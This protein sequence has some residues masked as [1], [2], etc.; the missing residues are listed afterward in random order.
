[1]GDDEESPV[2]E[3][4]LDRMVVHWYGSV[5][6]IGRHLAAHQRVVFVTDTAVYV[7]LPTGGVTR[8]M[9]VSRLHLANRAPGAVCQLFEAGRPCLVTRHES[10]SDRDDFI[11]HVRLARQSE[12][13]DVAEFSVH[14]VPALVF[15]GDGSLEAGKSTTTQQ[16]ETL[17]P[18]GLP[19]GY[20]RVDASPRA[21][22]ADISE[23]S[24]SQPDNGEHAR[25]TPPNSRT[26][27][28][29]FEAQRL[30]LEELR[31]SRTTTP[32]QPT[33][34]VRELRSSGPMA[35]ATDG[36]TSP[37][38][39]SPVTAVG[40]RPSRA[41]QA[42]EGIPQS[43]A[44]KN[45]TV[46]DA[47]TSSEHNRKAQLSDLKHAL[48]TGVDIADSP[49]LHALRNQ[50]NRQQQVID[51]LRQAA[52][53]TRVAELKRELDHAHSLISD[54]QT[55][56]RSQETTFAEMLRAQEAARASKAIQS[57]LE[58]QVSALSAERDELRAEANRARADADKLRAE[59][60]AQS[61]QHERELG[62]VREAFVQYDANVAEY[63][64]E[65]RLEHA[66]Q[67]DR[68]RR[69]E[70]EKSSHSARAKSTSRTHESHA[71]PAD[72]T[73]APDALR[74]ALMRHLNSYAN[75]KLNLPVGNPLP[76]L[77]ATPPPAH[78]IPRTHATR[79]RSLL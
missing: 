60:E 45:D 10:D 34:V 57:S 25:S 1:M 18:P 56:L 70:R 47:A 8:T 16:P 19:S 28:N 79:D 6:K 11:A 68:A 37:N 61:R 30:A 73:V 71:P 39:K 22:G 62:R 5:D 9:P 23:R 43:V 52:D 36:Q 75:A 7:C 51:E 42:R 77:D 31:S 55:A 3:P 46:V 76:V 59:K 20:R 44:P 32:T 13:G 53:T 54:L 50:V 40:M 27:V 14:D 12:T 58:A 69:D 26:A 17:A 38:D 66:A 64:E 67:L 78:G 65:V 35:P 63:L 4:A 15:D 33:L 72:S 74:S 48:D 24:R 29:P 49:S 2:H 21:G 41:N